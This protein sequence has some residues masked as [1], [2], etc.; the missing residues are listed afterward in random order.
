MERHLGRKLTRNED[1]H[2]KDRDYTNNAIDNLEVLTK[3]AHA[4]VHR[5]P[6]PVPRHLR[7]AR[8]AYMKKYFAAYRKKTA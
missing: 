6:N 2:H 7:P 8:Q 5:P 1:V 4:R 3:L